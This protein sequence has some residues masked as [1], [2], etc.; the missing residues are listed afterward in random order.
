[1]IKHIELLARLAIERAADFNISATN[2]SSHPTSCS[3]KEVQYKAFY[4]S[5]ASSPHQTMTRACTWHS[6]ET[7]GYFE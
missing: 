5:K 3:S 2:S 7:L 1:M 6:V 4:D